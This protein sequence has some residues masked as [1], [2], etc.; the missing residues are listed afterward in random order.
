MRQRVAQRGMTP[1]Q[2]GARVLIA[3]S[4]VF[5]CYKLLHRCSSLGLLAPMLHTV[6]CAALT[7]R[8]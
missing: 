6:E 5:A 7:A 1:L 4:L 3:A 8:L 2:L